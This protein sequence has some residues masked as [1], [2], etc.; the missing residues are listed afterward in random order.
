MRT[1]PSRVFA[2]RP[3]ETDARGAW[4]LPN[5]KTS[6]QTWELHPLH[7]AKERETE[8]DGGSGWQTLLSR[9]LFSEVVFT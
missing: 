2:V 4:H 6:R 8:N 5:L 3:E 7:H 1:R 9:S